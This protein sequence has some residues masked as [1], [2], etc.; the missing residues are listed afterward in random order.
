MIE[1]LLCILDEVDNAVQLH[2]LYRIRELRYIAKLFAR[3]LSFR[4]YSRQGLME[5]NTHH[6]DFEYFYE[7]N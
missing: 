7:R 2:W 6:H 4:R 5:M 1:L 3:G